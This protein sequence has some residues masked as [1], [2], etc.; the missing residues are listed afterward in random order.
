MTCVS[1]CFVDNSSTYLNTAESL[2]VTSCETDEYKDNANHKCVKCNSPGGVYAHCTTCTD[3]TTCKTCSL[4]K[5][6]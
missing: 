6:N 1:D 3:A 2:C 5:C 4:G